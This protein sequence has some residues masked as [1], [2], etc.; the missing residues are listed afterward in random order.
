MSGVLDHD[1]CHLLAAVIVKVVCVR[2]LTHVEHN[3]A[4]TMNKCMGLIHKT[5]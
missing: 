2:D 4:T 3:M 5:I 1:P